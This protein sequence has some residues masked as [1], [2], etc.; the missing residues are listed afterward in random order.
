MLVATAVAQA[1]LS[2]APAPAVVEKSSGFV[3]AADLGAGFASFS[4]ENFV[5]PGPALTLGFHG[6]YKLLP[7]FSVGAH[8]IDAFEVASQQNP[9]GGGS[10]NL[11]SVGPEVTLYYRELKLA[12]T[13]EF[14]RVD[15]FQHGGEGNLF[16]TSFQGRGVAV[17][18]AKM[19]PVNAGKMRAGFSAQFNY[20]YLGRGYVGT[21]TEI[22]R[23]TIVV[24]SLAGVIVL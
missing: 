9:F 13:A 1:E 19:W 20:A 2:P 3:F 12:L 8:V 14:L 18:I 22:Y 4:G 5:A 6:G 16:T 15:L 7:M 11:L 17:E 23:I 24:G 10:F 21:T